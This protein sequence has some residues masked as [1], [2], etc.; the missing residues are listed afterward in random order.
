LGKPDGGRGY[1]YIRGVLVD[2]D[3]LAV[4]GGGIKPRPRRLVIGKGADER[5]IPIDLMDRRKALA[6]HMRHPP[7]KKRTERIL[8][9]PDRLLRAGEYRKQARGGKTLDIDHLI[10]SLRADPTAHV[11]KVLAFVVTFIP[12]KHLVQP[13]VTGQQRFIALSD[14]EIDPGIGIMR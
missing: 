4:L 6:D 9:K 5:L 13:G 2:P 14:E 11:P 12:D 1:R 7:G 3:G 8:V 10:V